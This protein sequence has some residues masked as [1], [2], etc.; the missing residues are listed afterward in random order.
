VVLYDSKQA[1]S[2]TVKG[3]PWCDRH[4]QVVGKSAN[5]GGRPVSVIGSCDCDRSVSPPN[6]LTL[7]VKGK[8]L[9]VRIKAQ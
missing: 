9:E 5:K 8:S 1:L 2:A 3:F 6:R 7:V 4:P